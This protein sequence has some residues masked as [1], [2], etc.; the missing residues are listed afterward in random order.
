MKILLTGFTP[1]GGDSVNPSWEAVRRLPDQ[2]EDISI[3]KENI[4]TAFGAAA[5]AVEKAIGKYNP[6]A[7]ICTGLSNGRSL[8]GVEKAAI[9]YRYASIPDNLGAAPRET[10]VC[11]DGPAAYFATIPV[12]K[13]AEAMRADS[14]MSPISRNRSSIS[15]PAR[16][17]WRCP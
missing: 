6:D 10:P 2:L 11:P 9:N 8:I 15:L 3:Y 14:S 12:E 17:A 5:E 7:V 13:I 1:F 16:P 4:V